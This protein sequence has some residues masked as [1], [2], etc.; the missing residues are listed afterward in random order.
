MDLDNYHSQQ[1]PPDLPYRLAGHAEQLLQLDLSC[2]K[3]IQLLKVLR[4]MHY[5]DCLLEIYNQ[6]FSLHHQ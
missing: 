5:L 6:G 3:L 4:P 2:V 1:I